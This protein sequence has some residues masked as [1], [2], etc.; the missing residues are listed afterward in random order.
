MNLR[1]GMWHGLRNDIIV[2]NLRYGKWRKEI[3][4]TE[5]HA[6]VSHFFGAIFEGATALPVRLLLLAQTNKAVRGTSR[7][8]WRKSLLVAVNFTEFLSP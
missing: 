4:Y 7:G 5:K 8:L 2:W 6:R 3:N 1:N